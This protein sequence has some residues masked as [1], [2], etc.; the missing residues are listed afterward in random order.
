MCT[1][2]LKMALD[3]NS[4][5]SPCGIFHADGFW[6]LRNNAQRSKEEVRYG[7][8]LQTAQGTRWLTTSV[9]S[10]LGRKYTSLPVKSQPCVLNIPGLPSAH[11]WAQPWWPPQQLECAKASCR[12]LSALV[13]FVLGGGGVCGSCSGSGVSINPPGISDTSFLVFL[14]PFLA[15]F[16]PHHPSPSPFYV[17]LLFLLPFIILTQHFLSFTKCQS[18]FLCGLE[19][20]YN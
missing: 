9:P 13:T 6:W 17:L 12:R 14:L 10:L 20:A 18:F 5:Q 1:T 7:L 3:W 16:L 4:F 8:A 2:K 15:F 11:L 19:T